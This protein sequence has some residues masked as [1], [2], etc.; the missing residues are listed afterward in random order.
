MYAAVLR[1]LRDGRTPKEAALAAGVGRTTIFDWRAE[2]PEFAAAWSAA[3]EEGIDRLEN[4]AYRRAVEG[5]ERPVFQGGQCVGHTQEYSD[6]LLT[7]LLKGR[8]PN[9]YNT[10][11]HLHA[12][13]DG[14]P[15][16]TK[17]DVTVR[18]VASKQIEHE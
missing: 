10:E 16:H 14:G 12:G 2:D 9:V 8:R 18:F 13:G 15:I 5:V 11:R 6:N 3:V 1:C 4:E 7:L 17:A